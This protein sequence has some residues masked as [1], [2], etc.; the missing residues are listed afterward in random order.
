MNYR[1]AYHAGNFA[2]V[3]KHA[4]LALIINYLKLKEIQIIQICLFVMMQHFK[5]H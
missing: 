1:H 5:I 3:M 4:S 2:D